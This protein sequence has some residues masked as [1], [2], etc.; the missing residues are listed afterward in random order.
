MYTIEGGSLMEIQI[1]GRLH[2]QRTRNVFHYLYDP[3][4]VALTDGKAAA[5][6]ARDDFQTFMVD[7]LLTLVSNEYTIEKLSAQWILPT[8]Y[9]AVVDDDLQTGGVTG[10]SLP[11]YCAA[12]ISKYADFAGASWQG[13]TFFAG[14]P[15]TSEEDSQ[16]EETAYN[17]FVALAAQFLEPLNLGVPG[18]D[19]FMV[20]ST[21]ASFFP[22][23]VNAEVTEAVANR[24]LRAQRRREVGVGE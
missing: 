24:V 9:R 12:V 1:I 2:G 7:P 8:R 22:I 19:V 3:D 13:R 16:L 15:V 5:E 18:A 21:P 11:S 20:V 17:G 4:G 14:I 23:N 10:N 6:N